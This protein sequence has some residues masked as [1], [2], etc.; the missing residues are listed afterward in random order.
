[1]GATT[2]DLVTVSAQKGVQVGA[3]TGLYVASPVAWLLLKQRPSPAM[4][5]C[6]IV[7]RAGSIGVLGGAIFGATIALGAAV[8]LPTN[9][10]DAWVK[11]IRDPESARRDQWAVLGAVVGALMSTPGPGNVLFTRSPWHFRIGGG[12]ALGT[13]VMLSFFTASLNH[14]IAPNLHMVVPAGMLPEP[15]LKKRG[16]TSEKETTTK[17][18]ES[19]WDAEVTAGR[20]RRKYRLRGWLGKDVPPQPS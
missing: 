9:D 10:L 5:F 16:N 19:L 6:E 20:E 13:A 2:W 4:R 12:V 18:R 7:P 11:R 8:M 17:E 3:V 14:H 1:M 15:I